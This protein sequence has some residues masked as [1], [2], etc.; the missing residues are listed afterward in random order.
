MSSAVKFPK[1]AV[2]AGHIIKG[3]LIVV[4]KAGGPKRSHEDQAGLLPG[5]HPERSPRARNDVGHYE[6]VE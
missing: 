4:P 5:V 6:I 1:Y 3:L 2:L